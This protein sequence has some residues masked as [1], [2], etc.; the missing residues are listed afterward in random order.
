[1]TADFN[2][3]RALALALL[4]NGDGLNRRSGQFLG[5]IAFDPTPLT[6]NQQI[7]FEALIERAGLTLEA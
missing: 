7:W 6:P 1:M 2:S 5:G 4:N 3:R